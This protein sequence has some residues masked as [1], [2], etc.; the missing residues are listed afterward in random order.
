MSPDQIL[1]VGGYGEVGRRLAAQLEATQPGR[2]IVGGRHPEQVSGVRARAIDVDDPASIEQA[3]DGVSVVVACVRQREPHLLR[4]AVRRG[5]AYTSIAPP[6]MPWPDTDPLRAEAERTGARVVLAAGLE[7][8]ISSVLV[9]AA[10]ERLG[11]VDAVETALLLGLG[12]AYGADSMA[13]TDIFLTVTGTSGQRP[14]AG[15]RRLALQRRP[16]TMPC[17]MSSVPG[18]AS[19]MRCA[20]TC[21]PAA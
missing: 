13:F 17:K 6:W 20:T 12:D 2:V 4:A 5:I 9:R 15:R 18:S 8:G 11:R 3:L 10:A 7:P 21:L 1:I 14:T 16:I 19:W